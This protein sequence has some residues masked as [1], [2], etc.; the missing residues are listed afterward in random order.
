MLVEA[1]LFDYPIAV[2]PVPLPEEDFGLF[3]I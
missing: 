3:E 2:E 1:E